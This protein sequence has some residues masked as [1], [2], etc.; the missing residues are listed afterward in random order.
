MVARPSIIMRTHGL[1][2]TFK[3]HRKI[4]FNIRLLTFI[5]FRITK[6]IIMISKNFSQ[7]RNETVPWL[8]MRMALANGICKVKSI[9]PSAVQKL[10]M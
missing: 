5:S 10:K 3:D 4:F 8:I 7:S 6:G 2:N 9:Q 1:I